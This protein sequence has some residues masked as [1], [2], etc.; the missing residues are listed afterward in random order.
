MF[1]NERDEKSQLCHAQRF[2]HTHKILV[3]V[4]TI[5]AQTKHTPDPL[6]SFTLPVSE[7]TLVGLA[8]DLVH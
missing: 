5:V 1:I 8:L 2:R 6:T 4:L 7:L 3:A